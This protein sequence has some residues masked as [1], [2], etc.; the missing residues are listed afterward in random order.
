MKLK[1]FLMMVL[2]LALCLSCSGRGG[3]EEVS[4]E[5]PE[6]V[7]A[8]EVPTGADKDEHDCIGSA[9]YCWSDVQGRCI[10]LWEDGV[11]LSY[12]QPDSASVQL[13]VYLVFAS[14]SAK[15]EL[16]VPKA[17]RPVLLTKQATESK[18]LADEWSAGKVSGKWVVRQKDTI[19][20]IQAE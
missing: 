18:W 20:G 16:F 2:G 5:N 8:E 4:G 14:D 11:K 19:I 3:T 12:L 10:R 7:R 6:A 15:A 9:G 17:D 1:L 13:A